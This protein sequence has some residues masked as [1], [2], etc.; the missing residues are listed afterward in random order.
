[1]LHRIYSNR[2]ETLADYLAELYRQPLPDPLAAETIIVQSNGMARWLA[3][4]LASRLGV[5]ANLHFPFPAAFLWQVLRRVLG[6]VPEQS[7]FDKPVLIWRLLELLPQLEQAAP[8][9]SLHHYLQ[10]TRVEGSADRGAGDSD[11]YADPGEREL[12][13]YQLARRIA[14][15][16]DQYLVYRLD[17]LL[18]WERGEHAHWQAELWRR[19]QLPDCPHN[20]AYFLQFDKV[21]RDIKP[22]ALPARVALIGI[23]ALPPQQMDLFNALARHMDIHLLI[24]NPCREYWGDIRAERDIARFEEMQLNAPT[25]KAAASAETD[26]EPSGLAGQ[27]DSEPDQAALDDPYLEVGHPLLASWG[28]QGRDFIDLLENYPALEHEQYQDIAPCNLLTC[29]QSDILNLRERGEEGDEPV[30]DIAATDRSIQ[31]HACHSPLREIQVL[32]DQLLALFESNKELRPADIVVMTPDIEAYSPT[33][34]AVFGT[35][36][37]GR[38]IPF[39]I[40]DRALTREQP[41]IEAVLSLLDMPRRR[42]DTQHV[43]ALLEY[44]ALRRRFDLTEADFS[45][46]QSWL[47]ATRVRWG[48]DAT[49]RAELDLPAT[50]EHTWQAGLE[51][52]L[53]GYALPAGQSRLWHDV[54]PFDDVEGSNAQ[55]LGRLVSFIE[56]L[57]RF[58][59][60]A[61]Q[62]RPPEAWRDWLVSQLDTFF[63]TLDNEEDQLQQVRAALEAVTAAAR[64]AEAQTAFGLTLFARALADAL[65]DRASPSGFFSGGVTFCTLVPMRS[66]PFQVVCLIGMNSNS[67]PRPQRIPDFDLMAR[68]FRKGDRSRRN[69]D[70]YLFLEALLS[71]RYCFYISYIGSNIRD[72]SENPPSVLVSE[73]LDVLERGFR[74]AD[75]QTRL[76][77]WLLIRHPLQAFSRRYFDHNDPAHDSRLFSYSQEL[78]DISRRAESQRQSVTPFLEQ[79]LAEPEPHWQQVELNQLLEFY[80]NPV[81]FLLR[82][83]LGLVLEQAPG[84]LATTEPFLLDGL[85]AYQLRQQL[86]DYQQQ[87]LG[88]QLS[89]TLSRGAGMLPHGQV[90]DTVFRREWLGIS[91]FNG[92]LLKTL[93][94][95]F[96]EPLEVDILV[97]QMRLTGWLDRVASDGR[98]AFRPASVKAKDLFRLWLQH[99]ALCAV[100]PPGVKQQSVWI[101][102]DRSVQLAPVSDPGFYLQTLLDGYW[103]GLQQPL[104]FFVASAQQYLLALRDQDNPKTR[105]SPDSV[106]RQSW[107][108]NDYFPGESADPYYQLVYADQDPLDGE[109]VRLAQQL[110]QPVLEYMQESE[111]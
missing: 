37:S 65:A 54:L 43:L 5:S 79:P 60:E 48:I 102:L 31:L 50:A 33:I 24:L 85:E 32:H 2:V 80:D 110:W 68:Y 84:E 8:F 93:P 89:H 76:R 77:D 6:D 64:L 70:R 87:D 99:L 104:P 95:Q 38:Y 71:A 62:I 66:I 96:L 11:A 14:D 44:P 52:L 61:E 97:G 23:S 40:A 15:V 109:F 10:T 25:D 103:E 27:Q 53:S 47:R 55:V 94:S 83:R 42:F 59:R 100:A 4:Q 98:F 111:D 57:T 41:L 51:R 88:M 73:L 16:Y 22:A 45:L 19:L 28:K 81:R 18:T 58:V 107:L 13:R 56:S 49:E 72:N 7:P 1:M 63:L 12:R 39:T 91:R 67:Y 106:A 74:L 21:L 34:E 108:G 36:L 20:G 9:E 78:A 86:L 75:G 3:M 29:V 105:R 92:R 35:A 69:D 17:W 82:R 30:G 101:G 46:I 26:A 90:G